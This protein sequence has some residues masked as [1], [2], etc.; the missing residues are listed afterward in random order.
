MKTTSIP[1]LLVSEDPSLIHACNASA[2]ASGSSLRTLSRRDEIDALWRT[3]PSVLVGAD[4]AS[5][6]AA[7]ELPRRGEISLLASEETTQ[8]ACA[9]S[10]ALGA[11]VITVP[12]GAR[13][14][15]RA[16]AGGRTIDTG[17]VVAV[18]SGTG[19]IGASTVAVG[20]AVLGA[21]AGSRCAL[22]DLDWLGGGIDLLFGAEGATGW[23]WDKLR[24]ASGQI[25][26]IA[27]MLPTAE[28]V[29]FVSMERQGSVAPPP[30]AVMAVV[31]CLARGFDLVIIDG[32]RLGAT[33]AADNVGVAT[34]TLVVTGQSVRQVAATRAALDHYPDSHRELVVRTRRHGAIPVD[35]V[36]ET[37]GLPI[38]ATV[39]ETIGLAGLA[40]QG[41][42]P[43]AGGPRAWEQAC[44]KLLAAVSPSSR[45]G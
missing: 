31:D 26:D 36:A 37:I 44:R 20:L 7:W 5:A 12:D 15:S 40:D 29:T 13:W 27:P 22:V 10:M 21:R 3:A 43:G 23:R 38:I 42:A 9:W 19:G 17:V 45:E 4:L 34:M 16:L 6:V 39:P 32:G 14:L 2:A 41:I 35:A 24:S 1:S 33:W 18:T 30:E 8:Q 11:P 25:A 28:G